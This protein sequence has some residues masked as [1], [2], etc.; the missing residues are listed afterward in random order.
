MTGTRFNRRTRL[1]QFIGIVT[2]F[3]L[4]VTMLATVSSGQNMRASGLGKEK[5]SAD[6][7]ILH[8]LNR[9][10]FGV[11]SGDVERVKSMGIDKK[12][13]RN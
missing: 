3:S 8:V 5:L 13:D 12:I 4:A 10:G 1:Q 9:L 2:V 6:Q 11:R 7:R